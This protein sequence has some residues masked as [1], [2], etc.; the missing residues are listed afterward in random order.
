MTSIPELRDIAERCGSRGEWAKARTALLGILE[1]QGNDADA[2]VQL[3]YIESFSGHYRT[4]RDYALKACHAHSIER[5][6]IPE[7]ISRLRTFNE[8]TALHD[9]LNRLTPIKSVSIPL[10]IAC[11]AQLSYLNEQERAISMLDEAKRG[12]PHYPPLLLARGQVLSYL[13]RFDEAEA[14]L[15]RCIARAPEIAQAHWFLSRLRKQ[16]PGSNHIR[17]IE[18]QLSKPARTAEDISLLA[19]ALHK[20]L[21][22]LGDYGPAREALVHACKAKRSRLR[23]TSEESRSLVSA[24]VHLPSSTQSSTRKADTN[25]RVPIFI[26]GMHRSGTTLLEQL[27][28]G[29]SNVMGIGELYDFTSQMRFATDHHCR[30]VIDAKIVEHST[31]LDFAE[32]GRGYLAGLEWRLG[33]EQYF[34][35]KLPSNFLNIGFICQALPQAKILH[36]VRDPIETCF[37]NLREL[38][39]DANPYSYDQIEL[40]DYFLQYQ[41]LMRHWHAAYPG[42]IL[43]VSYAELTRD[44]ECVLRAVSGFCGVEFEPGMLDLS[45]RTRGIATASAVQVRE[46]VAAR[47]KPKWEPYAE[48]LQPMIQRLQAGQANG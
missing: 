39:S 15:T 29:H 31:A 40:A 36:M 34:T 21:D 33:K 7:L 32:V 12:D 24:L 2:L 45:T 17:T 8:A 27:I 44:P 37:S 35:D 38:F 14:D 16:T 30:G 23:Y 41:R 28:E 4:A 18:Q 26:V 46:K 13:G 19:Y 1:Q 43:D 11:S 47:E 20:E 22:D 9:V 10:L 42:R 3:S 25:E 6:V 5:A 48:Y